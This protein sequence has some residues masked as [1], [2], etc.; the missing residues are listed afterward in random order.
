VSNLPKHF[1]EVDVQRL[2][3]PY[4]TLCEVALHRR[5]DGQSKGCFFVSFATSVEGQQCARAL[6]NC[7]LPGTQRPITV[8]PSTSRRR[9]LRGAGM[10][11]PGASPQVHAMA[12][13]NGVE[14][15]GALLPPAAFNSP[16]GVPGMQPMCGMQQGMAPGMAQGMA[17]MRQMCAAAVGMGGEYAAAGGSAELVASIGAVSVSDADAPPATST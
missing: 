2:C 12:G 17:P 10:G 13:V 15:N 4:G 3:A 8:R 11:T 1:S 6:H 7:V 5:G 9:E 16:G 14:G